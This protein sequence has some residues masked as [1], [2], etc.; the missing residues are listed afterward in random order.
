ME[1]STLPKIVMITSLGQLVEVRLLKKLVDTKMPTACSNSTSCDSSSSNSS[2]CLS[3]LRNKTIWIQLFL[4]WAIALFY[5]DQFH[6]SSCFS[7]LRNKTAQIQLSLIW[8]ITLF[9]VNQFHLSSFIPKSVDQLQFEQ[10]H[11]NQ[12]SQP[13]IVK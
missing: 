12:L 11:F 10:L 3:A 6:S 8:G 13:Q 9:C 2:S 4:I 1:N 5:V 7:A